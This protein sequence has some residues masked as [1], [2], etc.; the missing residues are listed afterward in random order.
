V[1]D[2]LKRELVGVHIEEIFGS[3]P[4]LQLL[5]NSGEAIFDHQINIPG[6]G[7]KIHL[8]SG[9]PVKD[10]FGT[11]LGDILTFTEIKKTSGSFKH[12]SSF[13]AE[14]T[15]GEILGQSIPFKESLHLA[16]KYAALSANLLIQGESGTGKE[17]YAQAIHNQSRPEGPFVAINCAAIPLTLI[18]SELFGYE[19]G[20][21]T[22]A[23]R[24]GRTGKIELANEGTL[25]LDEIGDMPMELQPVLLRVLE[26]KRIMRIGASKYTPVNFRLITASNKDLLEL[27][28]NN[29]FRA[30]LYYRLAV[31][32]I[33]IPPLRERET[34]IIWLAKHFAG[35]VAEQQRIS[36]PDLS[37]QAVF[38]LLQYDWPGNVRELHN[39]MIYAVNMAGNGIIGPEHLP[40]EIS[41][42][43]PENI[44]N[45]SQS[46]RFAKQ[47]QSI[48]EME[49]IMIM[50]ALIN[51]DFN[52]YHAA[53]HL[54]ISRSTLYRKMKSYGL[55]EGEK[56]KKRTP[57][58]GSL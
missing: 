21:F 5:L 31:L 30:D 4:V 35:I 3:E 6:S 57:Q 45:A 14:S 33:L 43:E 48:Q 37:D 19:P 23:E 17:L 55:S 39:V 26:E 13:A 56:I 2:F 11:H 41:H 8:K 52:V 16:E 12:K 9:Q 42:K 1:F 27:V 50:Q 51:A 34:D 18:E 28:K 20:A 53:D 15:F 7:Q 54:G 36:T 44:N 24:K 25:F 58:T 40:R 22:G 10:K 29:Q 49:K 47:E 32:K 38:Q 46:T